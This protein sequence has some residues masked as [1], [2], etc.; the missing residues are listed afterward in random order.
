MVFLLG[1]VACTSLV[2]IVLAFA[3]RRGWDGRAVL[4]WSYFGERG[5]E[6]LWG[7]RAL[8]P[9]RL[10]LCAVALLAPLTPMDTAW[11]A[12]DT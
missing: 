1:A 4:G 9:Y 8:G 10:A 11:A 5:A 7:P 6:Y 12:A 3:S 2:N